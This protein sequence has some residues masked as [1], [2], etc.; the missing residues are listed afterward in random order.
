MIREKGARMD[1]RRDRGAMSV[2]ATLVVPV[3]VLFMLLVIAG[4]RVAIAG[5]AVA[6]A[7]ASAAREASLSSTTTEAQYNASIA[8]QTAMANS[9][10]A[11]ADLD[12][13]INDAGLDAPLGQV[14]VVSATV[15]CTV[16]MSDLALPGMP[17]TRTLEATA[18]SPVD[19]F[20]ERG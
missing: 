17:G 4:G 3:L 8:A 12:V 18:N 14:G 20:R 6:S 1:K 10:H 2:E 11:C 7:A 15:T 13:S 19:A 9:G 5:N 16:A